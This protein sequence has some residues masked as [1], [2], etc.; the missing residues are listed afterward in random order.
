MGRAVVLFAAAVIL[1]AG[2][3][4]AQF[5]TQVEEPARV[6]EAIVHDNSSLMFGWFDPNSFHMKHS[7]SFSY[8][9]MNGQGLSLGTYTNSMRYDFAQNFNARADVS[10]S[11]SPY[12]SIATFGK[13]DFSN[14][15]LSRAELNYRPW[16]NT[17]VTVQYRNIPYGFYDPFY[18]NSWNRSFGDFGW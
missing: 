9:S 14:V 3:S 2:R 10:M 7:V 8:Q 17:I 11:Y 4:D 15:Y 18:S 16:E 5:K 1:L 6:N 13:S 12:N